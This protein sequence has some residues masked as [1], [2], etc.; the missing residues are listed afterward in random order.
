MRSLWKWVVVLVVAGGLVVGT[1]NEPV[2]GH[3]EVL[4]PAVLEAQPE[5][6]TAV[7]LGV[8][9]RRAGDFFIDVDID[10]DPR[11]PNNPDDD[12][13]YVVATRVE[14]SDFILFLYVS[15]DSGKTWVKYRI[16]TCS[17]IECFQ[18]R[19]AVG[20]FTEANIVAVGWQDL[21]P[22][23]LD[24]FVQAFCIPKSQ[25]AEV[26][27]LVVESALPQ[28]RCPDK[29]ALQPDPKQEPR[30][31]YVEDTSPLPLIP[32]TD[33][34]VNVSNSDAISGNHEIG[35]REWAGSWDLSINS[36]PNCLTNGFPLIW[37]I[38]AEDI[39]ADMLYSLSKDGQTWSAPA[40]LPFASG[41][42]R[43][44]SAYTDRNGVM[45]AG[46]TLSVSP[47]EVYLTASD[48]CG[49]SWGPVV[50]LSS[51]PGFSD[52]PQVAV[53]DD[54]KVHIVWDDTT[55][56]ANVD[57][58]YTSC[59]RQG[60]VLSCALARSIAKDGAFPTLATDGKV[61]YMPY[62][63]TPGGRTAGVGFSCSTDGGATWLPAY[64]LP[65]SAVASPTFVM[66]WGY[67]HF[68]MIKAAAAGDRVY[69]VW[70]QAG[71]APTRFL[72]VRLAW[73]KGCG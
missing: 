43:F 24:V 46:S 45:Y 26:P 18:P 57:D 58:F 35:G 40:K 29:P 71:D 59:T 62:R 67:V 47:A 27:Q 73:R 49:A 20:S 64:E 6:W 65:G 36:H 9:G 1:A 4:E 41:Q 22:G 70:A 31:P 44:P 53:T 42:T 21:T 11:D 51:N 61:L 60:N 37:T 8:S 66:P 33:E 48:N 55:G 54:G 23:N 68:L 50:N 72:N 34:M 25:A 14:G 13:I 52:A 15:K 69:V 38:W 32:L 5:A 12:N 17:G 19:V 3:E 7:T 28:L 39:N 2:R 30:D 10:V 56:T 16:K 63:N